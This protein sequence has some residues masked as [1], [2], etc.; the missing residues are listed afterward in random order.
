MIAVA[1]ILLFFII[2][3][4]VKFDNNKNKAVSTLLNIVEESF[5][6]VF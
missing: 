6:H 5:G 1:V 3:F 4:F 2:K